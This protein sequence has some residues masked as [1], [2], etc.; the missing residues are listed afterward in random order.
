MWLGVQKSQASSSVE[1]TPP[2][3]ALATDVNV[4]CPVEGLMDRLL[5]NNGARGVEGSDLGFSNVV[6]VT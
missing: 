5:L 1:T 2:G 3:S 6:K 4:T